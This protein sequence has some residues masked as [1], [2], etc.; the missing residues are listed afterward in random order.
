M[1][2]QH[3]I[4]TISWT[5]ANKLLYVIYGF[6][7]LIQISILTPNDFALFALLLAINTWIFVICD[8]FALQLIV[9]YG[10]DTNKEKQANTYAIILHI[11]IS[12]IFSII[13]YVLGNQ[14][15]LLFNEKRFIE[16][17]DFLPLLSI[18]M[19]PRTYFS[20]FI[21]KEQQMKSL[22]YIDLLFFGTF[23]ILIIY[24]KV[25]FN[26]MSFKEAV[27]IYFLGASLSSIMARVL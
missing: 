18:L 11:A 7:F 5:V 4:S 21:I 8:S 25:Q 19:I 9:Q 1:K 16:V 12:I 2:L 13:I 14:L 23:T 10:F 24:F 27:Y 22:F 3:H 17:S 26:Y 20:K 15:A 6:I